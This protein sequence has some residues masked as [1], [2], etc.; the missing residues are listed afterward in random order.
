MHGLI[1][2]QQTDKKIMKM[3]WLGSFN[4]YQSKPKKDIRNLR[5]YENYSDSVIFFE[6]LEDPNKKLLV[7]WT[8]RW[9]PRNK[10]QE[11]FE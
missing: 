7:G 4:L 6:R 9:K 5:R 2:N 10:I 8:D 1:R 11:I 3:E